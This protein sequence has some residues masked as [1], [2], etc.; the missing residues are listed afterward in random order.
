MLIHAR[1]LTGILSIHRL[2]EKRNEY[3]ASLHPEDGV[4]EFCAV[5]LKTE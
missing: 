2:K 5:G 4:N 3:Q 1:L